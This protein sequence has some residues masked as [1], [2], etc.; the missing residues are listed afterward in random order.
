M[1]VHH[2]RHRVDGREP[3]YVRTHVPC[4]VVIPV[5]AADAVQLL[6]VVLVDLR[7]AIGTLAE[8][9]AEGVVVVHLLYRAGGIADD[10]VV[11]QMIL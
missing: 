9:A 8:Q 11:A 3:A 1:D 10:T 6:A 5:E 4:P 7:A 2:N